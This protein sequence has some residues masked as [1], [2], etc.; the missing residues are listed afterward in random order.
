MPRS[1][2]PA[3]Q[4]TERKETWVL[5]TLPGVPIRPVACS[6]GIRRL[7]LKTTTRTQ[8]V[9]ALGIISDSILPIRLRQLL[10]RSVSTRRA[11]QSRLQFKVQPGQERQP[12]RQL[13]RPF[14]LRVLQL[15]LPR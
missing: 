6:F 3:L 14:L 11:G 9:G 10:P 5:V 1:N 13:A 2:T 12:Q 8:F 4:M 15:H 7:S